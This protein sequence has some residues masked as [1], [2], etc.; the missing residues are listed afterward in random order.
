MIR[1]EHDAH[2]ALQ[3]A[4][5]EPARVGAHFCKPAPRRV[6][7]ARNWLRAVLRRFGF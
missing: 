5:R 3:R 6:Q 7:P 1:N 2:H 4:A